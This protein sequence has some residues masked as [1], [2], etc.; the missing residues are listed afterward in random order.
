MATGSRRGGLDGGKASRLAAE[1]EE[2]EP[3]AEDEL[4]R[5]S[6]TKKRAQG[7]SCGVR[8]AGLT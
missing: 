7:R 3:E 5:R 2:D 1:N 8:F 4:R 6:P